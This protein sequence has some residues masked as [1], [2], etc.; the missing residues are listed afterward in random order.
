MSTASLSCLPLV[1]SFALL[2]FL[3]FGHFG[4]ATAATARFVPFSPTNTTSTTATRLS[5]GSRWGWAWNKVWILEESFF[6]LFYYFAVLDFTF[7]TLCKHTHK[8]KMWNWLGGIAIY[9]W[10]M[11]KVGSLRS[12]RKLVERQYVSQVRRFYGSIATFA[13]S[14]HAR[15]CFVE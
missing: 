13:I 9:S 15:H 4:L 5:T 1:C 10:L 2:M 7:C 6:I 11:V 14:L 12:S 8:R 3:L